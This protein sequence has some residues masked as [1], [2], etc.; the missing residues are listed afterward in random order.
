MKTGITGAGGQLQIDQRINDLGL[1]YPQF[2]GALVARGTARQDA[3]GFDLNLRVKGPAQID[4]GITGRMADTFATADLRLTGTA[5][6]GLANKLAAPRSL[7]GPVRFDLTLTGPIGL[8]SLRGPVSISGGRLADPA[9]N[10]G[11]KDISGT[12]QLAGGR[13]QLALQSTVTSGGK[14]AVTGTVGILDPYSADLDIALQGVK[15]RDPDLYSTLINGNLTLRGPA[16]GAALVAGRLSLGRTELLIPSTGFGADGELPGLRHVRE[17][18]PSRATRARAGQLDVATYGGGST[19]YLLDVRIDAPNQVFIRG[20]GLDAELGGSLTLRGTSAAITPSGAF[21]LIR[22]RLDILG[23]RLNL[24]QA[25]LQLQGA[26]VPFVRIVASVESDGITAS[27]EIEGVADDPQVSFTASPD[28]PQE[29]VL[30]RLLFDRGLE[31][32]T[33][34]QAIQLAGAVATLAGR[35]GVGVIG[36]LRKRAGLDNLDIVTD[37]TGGADGLVASGGSAG[38]DRTLPGGVLWRVE[39]RRLR[40]ATPGFSDLTL[41]TSLA[42]TF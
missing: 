9:Q 27:V 41:V 25:L 31:N 33:A 15:L 11:F 29:E 26:L 2:P 16:L 23:R 39:A 14:V 24:S 7:S 34:F 10:F 3:S 6:A 21:N 36:N 4:A 5:S 30:A 19:G 37:G 13:A 18:G 28:L 32:L 42:V 8:G 22:G 35:G 17:P 1:L 12:A 20:R 40:A 38:V